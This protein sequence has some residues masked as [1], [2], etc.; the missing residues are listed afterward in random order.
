MTS[1]F[2]ASEL[3]LKSQHREEAELLFFSYSKIFVIWISS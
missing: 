1:I 3:Y 2:Q